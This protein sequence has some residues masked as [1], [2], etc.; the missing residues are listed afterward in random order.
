MRVTSW[1]RQKSG[2]VFLAA[3]GV[4]ACCLTVLPGQACA[5]GVNLTL[6]PL[7]VN[8]VTSPG[9]SVSTSLKV[10]NSGS[11]AVKLQVTLMKFKADS[12][13]GQAT[14]VPFKDGEEERT[15]S[16]FL[17]PTLLRSQAF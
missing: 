15:G 13:N 3:F 6:S 16:H 1:F 7:P 12:T 11:E 9:S 4:L 5:A 8:L 14:L 2:P 17:R 10:Q